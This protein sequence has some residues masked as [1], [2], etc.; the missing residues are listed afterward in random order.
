MAKNVPRPQVHVSRGERIA[1]ER[2]V[3]RR[4]SVR[5]LHSSSPSV[6]AVFEHIFVL[7]VCDHEKY[8]YSEYMSTVSMAL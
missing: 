6:I 2:L 4:V 8:T 5:T 7:R 1:E 3:I